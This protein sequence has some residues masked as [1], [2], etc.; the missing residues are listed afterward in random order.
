PT[1]SSSLL[2]IGC[3]LDGG[4]FFVENNSPEIHQSKNNLMYF[5][6][7]LLAKLQALG[8]VAAI[9]WKAYANIL[10]ED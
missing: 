2:D 7:T 3:S 9:D 10:R 1:D 6:F 4:A 8:T 5:L